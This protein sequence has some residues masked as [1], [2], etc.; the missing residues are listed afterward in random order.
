MNATAR[1]SSKAGPPG[2]RE[3]FTTVIVGAVLKKGFA[4]GITDDVG[5]ASVVGPVTTYDHH[6]TLLHPQGIDHKRLTYY[7][8]GI[9]HRL[10]NVHGSVAKAILA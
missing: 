1:R 7:H 2:L 6:A 4:Q 10:T 5:Y 9:R 3:G 8:D